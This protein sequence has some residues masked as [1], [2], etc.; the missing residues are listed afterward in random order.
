VPPL[1]I[2]VVSS[3]E[4]PVMLRLSGD[5]D[6]GSADALQRLIERAFA[7]GRSV[8]LDVGHLQFMDSTGLGALLRAKHSALLSTLEFRVEGHHGA[9]AS[10]MERTGTLSWLSE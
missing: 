8:V 5:L 9:V 3:D 4:G 1:N 2:D 10:V 6:W 7:D